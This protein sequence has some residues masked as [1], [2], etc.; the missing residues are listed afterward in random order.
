MVLK[1]PRGAARVA[2]IPATRAS[3]IARNMVDVDRDRECDLGEKI[4]SEKGGDV[5][6]EIQDEERGR[7]L[8]TTMVGRTSEEL[9]DENDPILYTLTPTPVPYL[10]GTRGTPSACA[11]RSPEVPAC[12]S[13]I[14]G[15]RR[16]HGSIDPALLPVYICS[17][18]M[19][20][21]VGP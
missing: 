13:P 19:L 16:L 7:T 14:S 15:S 18:Y 10:D 21:I 8:S 2:E 1:L 5:R 20:C 12:S 11:Y 9:V 6:R 17:V 3:L 4:G